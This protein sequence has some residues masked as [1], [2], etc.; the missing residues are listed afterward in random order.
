MSHPVTDAAAFAP[1]VIAGLNATRIQAG[2]PPVRLA[3]AQ[4]ATAVRVARQYFAA[5]LGAS[6]LGDITPAGLED[7]NTIALGLLAGWQVA[8]TIRDGIFFSAV[9]PHT[10]DAGRWV[11]S[12][13]SM[14]I[15]RNALMAPEI[16]EVALGSAMF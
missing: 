4:S 16:E 9:V 6:G 3:E 11:D 1:A 8:G 5:S 12:A 7:I 10:R 2:L 15:G 13:L 14:P